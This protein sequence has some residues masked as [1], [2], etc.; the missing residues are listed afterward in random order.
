MLAES[1]LQ[2]ALLGMASVLTGLLVW[3]FICAIGII[4][5]EL[6]ASPEKVL[7][8]GIDIIENG[9]RSTT[10]MEDLTATLWRCLAGFLLAVVTGI[11]LGLLMGSSPI[12]QGLFGYIVQFLRPLPPL[13]YFVLLILWFGTGDFSKIILLFLAAFP[14]IASAS[15]A[16][17]R[18]TN[19]L[20]VEA[21]RVLGASPWQI[22]RLVVF[23]SALPIIF[24][25]LRI[26]LA[27]S[28][29]TVVAAELITANNGIG[30]MIYSASHFLKNDVVLFGIIVLGILG[31]VLSRMVLEIDLRLVHWRGKM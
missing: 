10:F 9:Y 20:R 7:L 24:T 14:T 30:W 13:S 18:S 1:G 22:T 19:R 15:A 11:P 27:A 28:F 29:S 2:R 21:A 4:S 25:G 8:A 12:C 16:G 5:P 23:P 3:Y 26:A 31:V 17:V 6:L